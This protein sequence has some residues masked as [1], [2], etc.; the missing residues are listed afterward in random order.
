MKKKILIIFL[1]AAIIAFSVFAFQ[2]NKHR[3]AARERERSLL[4]KRRA[5]WLG[6]KS[7]LEKE[8]SDFK[9]K[10]AVIIKDLNTGWQYSYNKEAMFPSAR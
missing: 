8:V 7:L 5:A 1:S 3:E 4:E 2:Y 10:S 6:L 9:G